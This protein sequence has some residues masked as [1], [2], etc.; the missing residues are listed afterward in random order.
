M[1]APATSEKTKAL[2]VATRCTSVDQ[3][4]ETFH[5]FCDDSSF[6]VATTTTRPIGLETPFAI[7]LADRTPVLR[8]VCTVLDAW[9]TP[10]NP[11]KRPGIRL[12]FK[13]LTPDSVATYGK[14]RE[15][16]LAASLAATL[17]PN[18]DDPDDADDDADDDPMAMHTAITKEGP[19]GDALARDASQLGRASV[20]PQLSIV[21]APRPSPPPT[22]R[23]IP[24]IVAGSAPTGPAAIARAGATA[25]RHD[26]PTVAVPQH[27]EPVIIIETE[28]AAVAQEVAKIVADSAHKPVVIEPA[29]RRDAAR[30]ESPRRTHHAKIAPLPDATAADSIPTPVVHEPTSALPIAL[31]PP[32]AP[33]ARAT[34]LPIA[35]VPAPSTT[36]TLP[37]PLRPAARPALPQAPKISRS[38]L[39][40]ASGPSRP[41]VG[42]HGGPT[43]FAI[44]VVPPPAA[45]LD[46]AKVTAAAPTG[47][48]PAAGADG[49]VPGSEL[50][51]PAN[52]LMNLTDESI[53]GFVDCTIYEDGSNFVAPPEEVLDPTLDPVVG[54][55]LLAPRARGNSMPP[56]ASRPTT[57]PPPL[58]SDA[59]VAFVPVDSFGRPTT[60]P[61]W[62]AMAPPPSP[63]AAPSV[64]PPVDPPRVE[65]APAPRPV[66]SRRAFVAIAALGVVGIAGALVAARVLDPASSSND[67][68]TT[69]ATTAPPATTETPAIVAPPIDA[70]VVAEPAPSPPPEPEPAVVPPATGDEED[71]GETTADGTPIVGEGPC[72]LA[73]TSTP[74]GSTVLV[75]GQAIGPSPLT[76]AGPCTRRKVD[77]AH[78]RYKLGTQWVNLAADRPASVDIRL[79]R[80]THTMNITTFP[81]GATISIG[82]RRA[83]T[84]P[85]VVQVMGFSNVTIKVEKP[86]W[87]PV[88]QKV[89]TKQPQDKLFIRLSR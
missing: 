47:E 29:R 1:N 89:Y 18:R 46:L 36:P 24:R 22:P 75:D 23:A 58:S 78:P 79:V 12:G 45:P 27:D 60:I 83:G 4:V 28:P 55:P 26:K 42:V 73:V 16:A 66:R 56:P 3:F 40:P 88:T 54:A 8:G 19:D 57:I 37:I 38:T 17:A 63:P 35:K 9:S 68:D 41:A 25:S 80:P 81:I 74:A 50:I 31:R 39:P 34:P 70:A 33:P 59:P 82:G 62:L 43:A 6:F 85:A 86:G 5:R 30:A 61:P 87:K 10:A 64:A 48:I 84:S 52:P 49:R 72:L 7:Q 44:S 15:A 14:L 32:A 51:L 2:C 69:V 20:V 65:P 76:L 77:V 21:P 71:A 53:G 67:A 13:R 11:F